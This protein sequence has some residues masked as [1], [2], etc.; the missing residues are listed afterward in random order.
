MNNE[1]LR[2]SAVQSGASAHNVTA[3]MAEVQAAWESLQAATA[4][5]KRKLKASLELQKF[6]SS[7]SQNCRL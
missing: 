4:G 6:L 3:I 7:V 5:R 1:C 2:L